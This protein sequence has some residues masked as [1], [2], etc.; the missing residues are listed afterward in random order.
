M[1]A[2]LVLDRQI[3]YAH[4]LSIVRRSAH[5]RLEVDGIFLAETGAQDSCGSNANAICSPRR[6]Y[7]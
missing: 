7:V 1:H 3:D 5:H 2:P 4:Q 6:N